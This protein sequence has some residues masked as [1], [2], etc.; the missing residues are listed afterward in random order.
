MDKAGAD[1]EGVFVNTQN[2]VSLRFIC[3]D[4]KLQLKINWM[5]N[6]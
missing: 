2:Q 4:L 6:S 3:C 5:L 1:P